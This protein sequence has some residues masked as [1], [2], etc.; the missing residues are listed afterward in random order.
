MEYVNNEPQ[1]FV[2]TDYFNKI[3]LLLEYGTPNYD[4]S[5]PYNYILF[6]FPHNTKSPYQFQHESEYVDKTVSFYPN[7]NNFY[8]VKEIR[9][10]YD[11]ISEVEDLNVHMYSLKQNSDYY[12]NVQKIKLVPPRETTDEKYF[13]LDDI[14]YDKFMYNQMMKLTFD[15]E[16]PLPKRVDFVVL[17]SNPAEPDYLNI[18][19]HLR[20]ENKQ[21]DFK[22]YTTYNEEPQ[23]YSRLYGLET[24]VSLLDDIHCMGNS[25]IDK[26]YDFGSELIFDETQPM[27]E[28][29]V[30]TLIS[31]MM[32]ND[33][34]ETPSSIYAYNKDWR[35]PSLYGF[36]MQNDTYFATI[37]FEDNIFRSP[38]HTLYRY[39]ADVDTDYIMEVGKTYYLKIQKIHLLLKSGKVGFDG[40]YITHT[41]NVQQNYKPCENIQLGTQQV[42]VNIISNEIQYIIYDDNKLINDI[43]LTLTTRHE[44]T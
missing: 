42:E 17:A 26:T 36:I 43:V 1:D 33:Y 15:R 10:Y 12:I 21:P 39:I 14:S 7:I 8:M 23:Y 13:V 4:Y 5:K 37:P 2:L 19:N 29:S 35:V 40:D 30:N 3:L 9:F 20:V 28:H 11:D 6:Q 31:N 38:K 44:V 22:V 24:P 27:I 34:S 41:T 16:S 32:T 25:Y 18:N